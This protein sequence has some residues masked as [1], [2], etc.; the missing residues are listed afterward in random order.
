M[1]EINNRSNQSKNK[2]TKQNI[3]NSMPKRI[4]SSD[5]SLKNSGA[6]R[7]TSSNSRNTENKNRNPKKGEA[8]G[9]K[10]SSKKSK[11]KARRKKARRTCLGFF[12][13][14]IV[15]FSVI[16]GI[17][18][19]VFARIIE[20]APNLSMISI[21]PTEY[22]TIFKDM[23]GEEVERY[24]GD[25]NR[26]YV[27]LD[28]I[29]KNMQNAILSVED[30]RFYNHFGIDLK[31]ILRAGYTTIKNK[32]TGQSGL[33]GASTITQQ[34]IKNNVTKVQ[35][36]SIKTK[37][38]E[39]YLAVKYEDMLEEQLGSKKA[40]KDY[41]LELYLN[42]IALGHGYNGVQ[43]AAL[44]YFNKDA[45]ELTLAECA[46]IAAITN[47]PSLYSPRS[48]P[49]GNKSRQTRILGKMLEQGMITQEEYN[50]AIAEDIY[51]KISE[52][53]SGKKEVE[54]TVIHSYFADSA[55]DQISKDLQDKYKISSQQADNLLYRGGL[56]VNLTLDPN[57]QRIVDN[58]FLND[59]YFPNVSY[60]IDVTYNVSIIND[61]TEKQEHLEFKQFVKTREEGENFVANKRAQIEAGLGANE[62]ILA[63][64][65]NFSSQP[66]A[67]MVI[68]DYR[69]GYV[70]AI[71]GGRDEKLVNRGFNRAT[72]S[73]RQPGSVF[74][75]L[76]VFAPGIDMGVL[77]PATVID[78]APFTKGKYSPKNW[79]SGYRGLSTIRDGIRDSMNVVSVKA[80]DQV[81]VEN[82]YEYLLNFGF[83]TLEDDAHLATALGGL[84]HGVTQLEVT[85]A[86][87]AIANGGKYLEPKFY[88]TVLDRE[89][90]V[91]LDAN[92]R[93]SYQVIKETTA[94]LLTDMMKDVVTSGT[95]TKAK[96]KNISMPVAGKTGTTQEAK[97]LT[98]V[99]YTPYYVAGIWTGYDRY[100][101]TV[102]NMQSI[103]RSQTY[104]LVLWRDIMEQL[105]QGYENIPFSVPSGI[106]KATICQ[107]SGLL[108]TD[109][110]AKDPRGNRSRTEYFAKGTE[111]KEACNVH[112]SARICKESGK[113]AGEFCPE[114]LIEIRVGIVRPTP[115]TG[116]SGVDDKKYEVNIPENSCDI[117]L[118]HEITTEEETITEES[119]E[120]EENF[121]NDNFN[122][123]IFETPEG[124]TT[125]DIF[126]KPVPSTPETN[127]SPTTQ[128]QTTTITSTETSTIGN[129]I[130]E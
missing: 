93:E 118:D 112:V 25:E 3:N 16:A 108:A 13:F 78:D 74:K 127:T 33:E 119:S 62:K 69:N 12:I 21:E 117:H 37:I 68:M 110:C 47:N 86:Y 94:F 20:T 22:T 36:N 98:F 71:A 59:E 111:P 31:G 24:H 34:L 35:R 10:V 6:Q 32:L 129:P 50:T 23:N 109:L 101:K 100:D 97:D 75:V 40:A 96:F 126:G 107:E 102:K 128:E 1:S 8:Q 26:E 29:P 55:F 66:Q 53:S 115:Y 73:V 46:S 95:G 84:T 124:T 113:L 27:S 89:G 63:E 81:G 17:G 14:I 122:G 87:G 76:A 58:A 92:E 82:C 30:E 114:D 130:I 2:I 18:I 5:T 11:K 15:I 9:A 103:L 45:N 70:R 57:A 72:N 91:L 123:D 4:S 60:K 51:A 44:G 67:S 79:Y 90:N 116:S 80:M 104:H 19:G 28:K 88:T 41:V 83:T 48:N 85:A 56:Q 38:Q 49:E 54:G 7:K 105:H 120:Y 43:A 61:T 42:T 39:Q 121:G 65:T 106:V 64:R 77:T 99:G 52:T 125:P